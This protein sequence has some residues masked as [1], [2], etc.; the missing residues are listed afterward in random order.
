MEPQ[1]YNFFST[2]AHEISGYT[3]LSRIL[4]SRDS[5]LG[6][7]N[8]DV[9]YDLATLAF[10]NGEQLEGFHSRIIILQQEIIV[11]GDIVSPTRILLQY[12]KAFSKIDKLRAFI[13]PKMA[14]LITFLDNNIKY[15]VYKV[16]D[17]HGIYFYLE[18]I[19]S[20]KT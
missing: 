16:G 2:Q 4:H 17:M 9:Q 10:N 3:I 5:H 19:R 11:S 1:A 18:M 8:S 12:M 20:P 15:T 6:G 7:M 14:D 13:A